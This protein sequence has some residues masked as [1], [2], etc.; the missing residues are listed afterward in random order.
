MVETLVKRSDIL[1]KKYFFF[2]NRILTYVMILL[3]PIYMEEIS[4]FHLATQSS[5]VLIYMLFMGGQWYLLGKEVDY[6]FKIYY[7]ANSSIE[8]ILYRLTLGT[9]LTIVLFNIF[10]LFPESISKTLFWIF[11]ACVALFYSWPTRGKIIEESMSSQFGEYKFLDSFEKTVLMVSG[12]MFLVSFPDIPLFQNIEALKLYLDPSEDIHFFV[13]NFLS[14]NYTPFMASDKLFN[15]SWNFHV[16]F[17]G[18]GVYLLA[19]YSILR[20]FFSRRLSILG[21]FAIV[22]T[23]SISIILEDNFSFALTTTYILLWIWSILWSIKSE[24]YRSGLFTGL[25]FALG[26]MINIQ[27]I[28]LLPMGIALTYFN[29]LK[30]KTTWYKRQWFKYNVLGIFLSILVISTHFELG[31]VFQ[32]VGL[33]EFLDIV[34]TYI[35]RKAFYTLSVVAVALLFARNIKTINSKMSFFYIDYLKLKEVFLLVFIVVLLGIFVNPIYVDGFSILWFIALLSLIPLEWIFQSIQRLRSKRNIIFAL[36]IL[37][38]LMDS[39]F[40][41]RVRTLTKMLFSGEVTKYINNI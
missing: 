27:Y 21:I 16:Y 30:E 40:E 18:F 34:F 1:K 37:V 17:L 5:I 9:I 8:R 10:S 15:L 38:C 36:Y 25:V 11:Y 12:L 32:G 3:I 31:K 26:V 7:K 28:Y 29:F 2:L 41:G 39:H 14:I 24:T 19:F 35:E 4:L 6:R 33:A 22:S 23:W 13:W 20:F